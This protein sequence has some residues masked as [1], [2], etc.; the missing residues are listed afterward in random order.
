MSP[1]QVAHPVFESGNCLIG[2]ASLWLWF[3]RDREA[4]E[5]PLPRPGDGALLHVDL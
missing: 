5:R 4:K 1:C 3:V 2:D